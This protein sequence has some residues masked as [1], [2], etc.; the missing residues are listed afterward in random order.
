MVRRDWEFWGLGEWKAAAEPILVTLR[1]PLICGCHPP[2]LVTP[3]PSLWGS[4]RGWAGLRA[5]C[6]QGV[7]SGDG[8]GVGCPRCS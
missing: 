5:H 1:H 2:G 7:M 3:L 6:S 8:Q 4:W